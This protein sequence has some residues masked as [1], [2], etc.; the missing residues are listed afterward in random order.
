MIVL[1]SNLLDNAIEGCCRVESQRVLDCRII[2]VEDCLQL[3]VRNS[4]LPVLILG[5]SIPTSKTPKEEHGFGIPKIQHIV[6]Q[7]H[8]TC[9]FDY[10]SG[11]F[12]F[13]A[14]LPIEPAE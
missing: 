9:M 6:K 12:A 5:N 7:F 10:Q 11:W 1:L 14:E 3:S 8:G 4:S 13:V 2:A